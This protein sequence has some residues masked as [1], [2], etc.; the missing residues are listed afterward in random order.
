MGHQSVWRWRQRVEREEALPMA[1]NGECG[2]RS[3]VGKRTRDG[4]GV[5]LPGQENV[6]TGRQHQQRVAQRRRARKGT[7]D[8]GDV[9]VV[10]APLVLFVSPPASQLGRCQ[11]SCLDSFGLPGGSRR[12]VHWAGSKRA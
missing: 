5:K 9:G 12:V 3:L 1:R 4:D 7:V 11:K 6:T 8:E 2:R 10:E